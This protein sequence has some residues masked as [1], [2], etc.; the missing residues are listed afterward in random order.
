ML[1]QASVAQQPTEQRIAV[2]ALLMATAVGRSNGVI[3]GV[4]VDHKLR[5]WDARS[6]RVSHTIDIAG[7]DLALLLMSWDGSRVLLADYGSRVTVWNT[8]TA[9][10]EWDFR[11]RRYLTTAAFSRDGRLLAFAEGSPVQIHDVSS[12]QLVRQLP[13][14]IGTT[15]IVFS[16][17][18]TSLA[19]TDGDSL[20]VYDVASGRPIASNGAFVGSGLT[21]DFSADGRLVFASGGDRS[22]V[23]IDAKTGKTVRRSSKLADAVFYLEVSPSGREVGVVTQNA[24]DPTRPAPVVVIDATSLVATTT[25]R[26][27]SGVLLPGVGWTPDGKLIVITQRPDTLKVWSIGS[28]G[29]QAMR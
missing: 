25:W 5:V 11:V 14:T 16:R 28:T 3:A 9:A 19:T 21:V 17:D 29:R 2:P 12:H 4:S 22:V 6:G 10:V 8:A 7:R 20:R 15:S 24:D 27:P 13:P 1:A 18:G 23:A 26:S